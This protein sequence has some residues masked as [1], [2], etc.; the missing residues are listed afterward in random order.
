MPSS[1][2]AGQGGW[3]TQQ[4]AKQE[5]YVE[6]PPVPGIPYGKGSQEQSHNLP[7]EIKE[8]DERIKRDVEEIIRATPGVAGV[9][10]SQPEREKTDSEGT[11]EGSK[12]ALELPRERSLG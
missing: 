10:V 4:G 12:S 8:I 6:T 5:F 7:P 1:S 3:R 9:S 2:E 11:T